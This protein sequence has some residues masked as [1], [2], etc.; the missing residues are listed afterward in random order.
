MS[1]ESGTAILLIG[2]TGQN[3]ATL[4]SRL[5]AGIPGFVA[6]G[7]LG[8]L[9][10]RA[11]QGNFPCGCG[12]AFHEC[13]FW[14]AV[15]RSAFGGWDQVDTEEAVR[16]RTSLM[17]RR[18]HRHLSLPLAFPLMAWPWLSM[19]YRRDLVRYAQLV[20]RIYE[21][22]QEVS[23]ARVIVDSTKV[24]GHGFMLWNA[25]NVDLR[26][27]HLVRDS[28]GVAFSNVRWVRSQSTIEGRT[29]RERHAPA[30][31]AARWIWINLAY[32]ALA[33]RGAPLATVRYE[34]LVR[35][36]R[37][38]LT[39]IAAFA[40]A[41]TSSGALGFLREGEAELPVA[42]LVAGNRLRFASGTTRILADEEWRAHLPPSQQRVVLA[43]T[44]PLV[45]R[46]RRRAAHTRLVSAETRRADV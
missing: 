24:P 21:G 36:P 22:V 2:G 40:G 29:Y 35:D 25:G 15:G 34:D 32:E 13:P 20:Q 27:A 12:A 43:M 28:R 26:V 37:D 41:P 5:L 7:E 30:R 16:L 4:L 9:W 45:L 38:E 8:F 46:Y 23:G 33:F 19:R 10:D 44:W 14:D 6:I 18:R 42:H 31:T 3:G 11:L 39:R 1:E 17:S